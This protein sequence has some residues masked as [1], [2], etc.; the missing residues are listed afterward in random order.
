[1]GVVYYKSLPLL[2]IKMRRQ[3][4][5][6]MCAIEGHGGIFYSIDVIESG[7]EFWLVPKWLENPSQ[8]YKIPERAIRLAALK[9]QV[10]PSDPDHDF[11]V[12]RPIPKLYLETTTPISID[13]KPVVL[14]Q[15]DI[16]V[17]IP[18]GIH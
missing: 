11:W 15:P 17:L 14:L 2:K 9:H 7:D 8:G 4:L 12:S 6:A 3:Q 18:K 13:A 10:T 16:Q 5:L 1:M